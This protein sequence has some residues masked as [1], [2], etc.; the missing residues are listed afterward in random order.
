MSEFIV[1]KP[2][3]FADG[4]LVPF[5]PSI[6]GQYGGLSMPSSLNRRVTY[7]DNPLTVAIE[8]RYE[9]D[10]LQLVKVEIQN[11]NGYVS[12]RDLLQLKLPAVMRQVAVESV[13]GREVFLSRA[14]SLLHS[15]AAIKENLFLLAQLYWLEAV[16]WGTPRKAIMEISGC[17]RSSANEYIKMAAKQYPLPKERAEPFNPEKTRKFGDDSWLV[18]ETELDENLEY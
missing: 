3:P 1:H 14:S 15:P 6:E 7:S 5:G 13:L 9:E 4:D 10:K 12:T 2:G 17:S 8:C 18:R 16:T 11:F